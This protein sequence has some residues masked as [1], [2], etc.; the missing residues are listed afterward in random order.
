MSSVNPNNRERRALVVAYVFPPSGG[1]GVQRVTKFVRDLPEFGWDCS[2]LTV[3]NP[4]V[5][6]SDETL[7]SEVS[8]STI[9]RTARTLEPGYALKNAISAGAS[10]G[11]SDRGGWK[12]SLKKLIRS[13]GNAVLQPDAQMLWYPH[14]VR[15]GMRLL[16]ELHH[17]A[18][19]VTAPPFSSFVIGSELSRR[20]G[21]P[22]VLVYRDEWGISNQYQENRQQLRLSHWLQGSVLPTSCVV[23]IDASKDEL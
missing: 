1:A 2:V 22:L 17:D 21:L 4:S 11:S 14:A 3:A 18:I 6:V 8:E 10:G 20:S 13:T 12:Q 19:F 9:V 7:M 15:E 5:P 23:V 16:D